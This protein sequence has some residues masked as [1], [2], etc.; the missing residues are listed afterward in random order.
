MDLNTLLR[1]LSIEVIMTADDDVTSSAWYLPVLNVCIN[2]GLPYHI[3]NAHMSNQSNPRT[4]CKVALSLGFP[5]LKSIGSLLG[6]TILVSYNSTRPCIMKVSTVA[7]HRNPI[8][9]Q[10][11]PHKNR[12]QPISHPAPQPTKTKTCSNIS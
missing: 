4:H 10:K 9:P 1:I 12:H 7:N 8:I 5:P 3:S 2:S 11:R 6:S